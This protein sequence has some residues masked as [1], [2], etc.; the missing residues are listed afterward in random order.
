MPGE[1]HPAGDPAQHYSVILLLWYRSLHSRQLW[2]VGDTHKVQG[3]ILWPTPLAVGALS[4][5]EF[6][7]KLS[8]AGGLI[9]TPLNRDVW[10]VTARS[11]RRTLCSL[12]L[13]MGAQVF[14]GPY[15]PMVEAL[16]AV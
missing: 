1:Y 7:S 4:T 14:G 10:T 11:N 5:V 9:D 12:D 16:L 8:K 6:S 3:D 2:T 15:N 13:Y